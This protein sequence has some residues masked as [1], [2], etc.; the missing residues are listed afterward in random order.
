MDLQLPRQTGRSTFLLNGD[1]KD[2]HISTLAHK[3][4]HVQKNIFA[5]ICAGC[6][7]TCT[8]QLSILTTTPEFNMSKSY[9]KATHSNGTI[10]L[11]ASISGRPYAFAVVPTKLSRGASFASKRPGSL[12][13]YQSQDGSEIVVAHEITKEEYNKL[14]KANK[15]FC[16]V[17]FRGKK[18]S[19]SDYVD[20]PRSTHAVCV[21]RD[22]GEVKVTLTPEH[23]AS[24][25]AK[26]PEGFYTHGVTANTSVWF[27]TEEHCR[28]VFARYQNEHNT[29]PY[30]YT[31]VE[32]VTVKQL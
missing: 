20:Q 18:Y 27:G 23:H 5:N 6:K 26:Y 11:R 1:F 16:T 25:H 8:L 15:T 13:Q 22:A 28:S 30:G 17:T 9:F 10:H 2:G 29:G 21:H 31:T 4:M 14:E 3:R 7:Q 32:L 19:N 12:D 24:Y